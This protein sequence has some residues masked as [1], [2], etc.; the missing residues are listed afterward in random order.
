[1]IFAN[2]LPSKRGRIYIYQFHWGTDY[3]WDGPHCTYA[4][5][6][7]SVNV[8]REQESLYLCDEFHL[9]S[10]EMAEAPRIV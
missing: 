7:G 2:L 10:F 9:E 1:M 8:A 3:T 5:Y 4:L 6:I